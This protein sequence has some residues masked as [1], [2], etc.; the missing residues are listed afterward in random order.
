MYNRIT[1]VD[2]VVTEVKFVNPISKRS[3]L[4]QKEYMTV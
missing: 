1:S 2:F 3:K 4:A